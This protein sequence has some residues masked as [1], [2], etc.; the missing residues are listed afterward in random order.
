M[1]E[2]TRHPNHGE[3]MVHGGRRILIDGRMAL[4]GGWYTYLANVVRRLVEA[5]PEDRF[6]VLVRSQRTAAALPKAGNLEVDTV[7]DG[8]PTSRIR[9]TLVNAPRLARDWAADLFFS[10]SEYAPPRAHCPVIASFRNPNLFTSLAQGWP[11]MQRVRLK[12]LRALARL[13]A[14]TCDRIMFVSEDSASW[15]GDAAGVPAPKRV[16][17]HHGIDREAWAPRAGRKRLERPYILSVSTIY[18]YKNYVRLIEAWAQLARRRPGVPDL[19]IIGDVQDPAYAA[20]LKAARNATGPLAERIHLLGEV[21]YEDVRDY[22]AGAELFVFPSY[23]ETFGHPL[24]EAMASRIPLVA[25]DIPVFREIA[26]DAALYADPFRPES[27]AGAMEAALFQPEARSTLVKSGSERVKEFS[28]KHTV[29][30]LSRLFDAVLDHEPATAPVREPATAPI[31]GEQLPRPA[32]GQASGVP[33][34]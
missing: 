34:G 20:D 12:T 11:P 10:V 25:A 29:S 21:L 9:F 23:L 16:V 30:H 32:W 28:W 33:A 1:V 26:A 19:V 3:S 24:L 22:Y 14:W 8:G 15:I 18:R 31:R 6:R 5:C 13:S 27:I 17:I 4:N 7:P 2:K